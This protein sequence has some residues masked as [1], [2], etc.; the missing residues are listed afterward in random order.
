MIVIEKTESPIEIEKKEIIIEMS[1]RGPSGPRGLKGDTGPQGEKGDTGPQGEQGP[2][3]IQGPQGEK[4]DT[5]DTGPKGEK[6]N[7]GDT[8]PQGPKGDKGDKGDTGPQG[9]K[10]DVGNAVWGEIAGS[11]GNQIDLKYALAGKADA[12]HIHGNLNTDGELTGGAFVITNGDR[13]LISDASHN[14]RLR[15]SNVIFDGSTKSKAL[16]QKGTFESFADPSMLCSVESDMVATR[17]YQTGDLVSVGSK[18][19]KALSNIASG[20]ALVVGSN[21][22]ET[23]LEEQINGKASADHNHDDRYYTETETNTLLN[24]KAPLASPTF[25][26]E[27]KAPTPPA[28]DYSTK[29]A[30]TAFVQNVAETKAD[31]IHAIASGAIA[32]F[33]DG[34]ANPVDSLSVSIEPV[35]DLHGQSNPYPAGWGKNKW[36]PMTTKTVDGVTFT[37]NSD[38]S[39][40]LTGTAGALILQTITLS[41]QLPAGTY[42][43]S[44]HNSS[45]NSNVSLRIV[46]TNSTNEADCPLD[47]A[48]KTKTFTSSYNLTGVTIRVANGTNTNGIVFYPQLESG[49]SATPYAPYENICPIVG[50]TEAKIT[51]AGKNLCPKFETRT[52]GGLTFTVNDDGIVTVTGTNSSLVFSAIPITLDAGTYI[53]S[54]APSNGQLTIRNA[55]G[56]G[57]P[58][59]AYSGGLDDYGNGSTFTVSK[60]ASAYLN[61]R[62][63]AGTHNDIYKPMLRLASD[64]DS[65]YEPYTP[66]TV[67]IDLDG[68]RYGGIL[69]VLPG[70]MTVTHGIVDLGTK[71]WTYET[72]GTYP[73]FATTLP[74]DA[75]TSYTTTS[76]DGH[77]LN[78]R[79]GYAQIV[80]SSNNQGMCF[81]SSY[82]RVRDSNYTD[83]GTFKTSISGSVLVY[84]LAT[85]FTVQ[86][87][88]ATMQILFGMNNIWADTGDVSVEYRADTKL[89]IDRKIEER[90]R[91]TKSIISTVTDKM[92]APKNLVSGDYII[93]GDDLLKI[94]SNVQSGGTLT[95][96]TNCTKT[97][98]AE[99]L[100]ALASS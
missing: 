86:L 66:Q 17:N 75:D 65:T 70:E 81:S 45:M 43:I 98:V 38:G 16:T 50:W 20:S 6:G 12:D 79:Y 60:T 18:V 63:V 87:T 39:I 33:P 42:T 15:M 22:V 88:P 85:P 91:A 80:S 10:G 56:G 67:T 2:Q 26:G 71:T 46:S 61:I 53:L 4:G 100:I 34:T 95:L 19:Y 68:T 49:S 76:S 29:L 78:D 57:A 99:A 36:K 41:A 27:P 13:L 82:I 9:P 21:V 23:T 14:N 11:I 37:V 51:R 74:S 55:K 8:G 64:T 72:G 35:Q 93:V 92:V 54:G 77:F 5:G 89:Y 3:G 59:S 97:T 47:A 30:T 83:V 73:F 1:Q 84:P 32:S 40:K 31:V 96:G 69:N 25:T 52:E 90:T 62:A 7:T 58:D 44:A 24:A 28:D 48:N 94:T